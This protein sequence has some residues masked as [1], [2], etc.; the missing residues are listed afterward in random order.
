MVDFQL[1]R[2]KRKLELAKERGR[3]MPESKED[4]QHALTIM[5]WAHDDPGAEQ[6]DPDGVALYRRFWTGALLEPG[7]VF[8]EH[9]WRCAFDM[10]LA[11]WKAGYDRRQAEA[12]F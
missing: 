4:R 12:V 8:Q 6:A 2:L 9:H 11:I 1:M 5:E 3:C 7:E 10:A